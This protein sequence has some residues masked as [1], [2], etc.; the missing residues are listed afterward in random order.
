MKFSKAILIGFMLVVGLNAHGSFYAVIPGPFDWNEAKVDA[1][2]RGGHLATITSAAEWQ[3]IVS[4]IGIPI[5]FFNATPSTHPNTIVG[6]WL[7]AT[8][9]ETE[10]DWKW[11]TGEPWSF[12]KWDPVWG[13][14]NN[15][16]GG[17]YGEEDYLGMYGGDGTWNDGTGQY[18]PVYAPIGY[19]LETETAVVP[20]PSTYIAGICTLA[21]LILSFT[22]TRKHVRHSEVA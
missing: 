9:L 14:P 15:G 13:E 18:L 2:A 7:G 17:P 8:D 10:G 11:I 1:E 16:V 6:V 22:R 4:Q 12:T 3:E 21:I 5:P 20:E 19:L